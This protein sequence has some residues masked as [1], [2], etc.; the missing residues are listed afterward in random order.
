MSGAELPAGVP[1]VVW[2]ADAASGRFTFVSEH[3]AA[4]LGHPVR[5][6]LADP[7]F[8]ASVLHPDDRERVLAARRDPVDHEDDYRVLAAD[9]RVH[10]VHDVVRVARDADG[11]ARALHGVLVD[12]STRRAEERR[13]RF[14]D[15]LELRLQPLVDAEQ[16]IAAAAQALVEHLGV[17]RCTYARAEE[18]EDHVVMVGDH[19]VGLPHLT[20]RFSTRDFGEGC[21]EAMRAGE[22]WVITDSATDPRVRAQ[23]EN[24]LAQ[25]MLAA[26]AVPVH[27]AGRYAGAFAVHHGSPRRWSPDE[28]ALVTDVAT[29]CW[30]SLERAHAA[31]ELRES[32]RRY[33]MLFEQA[34]DGVW[35]A[36][37]QL[38]YVAVNPAGCA[39][40]GY[41]QEEFLRLSVPDLLPPGVEVAL[42]DLL[43]RLA[44]GAPVTEVWDLLRADGTTIPVE[45]SMLATPAGLQSIGRDVTD[46]RRV[47]VE[48]EAQ[49][50]REHEIA[51]TL[52][53][54]LLP[55]ELP[56]LDGLA[57]AA[58]YLPASRH[59][60][61][62]GDWYDVLQVGD[63]TVALVVGDVVGKGPDAAAVMGQLRSALAGALLDGNTPAAALRR[64]E[65]FADRTPG[66]LGST[67]ACLL[68][69]C[70]SG[71]LLWATAGHPPPLLL[72]ANGVRA[73]LGEAGTVLCAGG[74]FADNAVVVHP[75]TT[76]VLY[77]DGLIE[78]RGAVIDD[79]ITALAD[80]LRPLA[81]T[82]PADLADSIIAALLATGHDDDVALVV[83]R[84]TP[85]PLV[86]EDV[87]ATAA[88]LADI[89]VRTG[90]WAA[91]A[92]LS[93]DAL[94]EL[95]LVLG[96]AAANAIEHAYPDEP[97]HFDYSVERTPRG[98]LR[99][100]VRDRGAWRPPPLDRGHRGRGL[101]MI[102]EMS[103][104]VVTHGPTGTHVDAHLVEPDGAG[105][106]GPAAEPGVAALVVA[107]GTVVISGALDLA[108]TAAVREGLLR[109][110]DGAPLVVDLTGV[111]HLSSSGVALFLD[112]GARVPVTL[113]TTTGS[114]PARVLALSGLPSGPVGVDLVPG[115]DRAAPTTD[116][117]R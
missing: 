7:G 23:R 15:A 35:V 31:R 41:T 54:S 59:A 83:G 90:R 58:H 81:A 106:A 55:R 33:R 3:G 21:L 64:L 1:L 100:Q 17:D 56:D 77:T 39:L 11:T 27:K 8:W 37:A 88:A 111:T 4:L 110:A 18:D 67:C 61:T 97:G 26:I 74:T 108:G 79:G 98:G 44:T 76:L 85:P 107:G 70:A 69:D 6:W 82:G 38:R 29:R 91:L 46:R 94:I 80:H 48:R 14:L 101:E 49:L 117:P 52:Q 60:Q 53:R 63:G 5:A 36:D 68:Y 112:L 73:L 72:D 93:R 13:E 113:R 116:S 103:T 28:V 114:A 87:P 105:P 89:R 20:G 104:A 99:A 62:G 22:P 50:R 42:E 66:A 95:N 78:R 45:L 34:A 16:I 40:M 47:E 10:W 96:E 71:V 109:R 43:A 9:G 84:I 102:H 30:E 24:Y 32:E 92:G 51:D 86:V 75:G 12:V 19:A 57:L 115:A 65:R 25:G 2:E